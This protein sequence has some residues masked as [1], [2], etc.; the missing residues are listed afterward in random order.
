M[1]ALLEA[2]V[3]SDLDNVTVR[4]SDIAPYLAVLGDRR[5]LSDIG[6]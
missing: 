6:T 3:L 1:S 5:I 2:G 4:I